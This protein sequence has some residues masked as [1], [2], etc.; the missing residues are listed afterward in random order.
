MGL[1]AFGHHYM[2]QN[3]DFLQNNPLGN[4]KEVE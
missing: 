2:W 1:A 3:W 4:K